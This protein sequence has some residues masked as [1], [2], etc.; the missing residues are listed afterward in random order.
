MATAASNSQVDKILVVEDEWIIADDLSECLQRLG[1]QV[2]AIT[3]TG[4]EAL[5]AAERHQ[6]DVAFMDIRLRGRM[7][8]IEVAEKSPS[9]ME[10]R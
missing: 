10:F 9:A 7:D 4:E 2:C 5:E 6:P 8:G 1:Y 3:S